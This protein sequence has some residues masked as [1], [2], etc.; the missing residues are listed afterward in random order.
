MAEITPDVIRALA[1][2]RMS[3]NAIISQAVAV[4]DNAGVFA[5]IDEATGYDIDLTDANALPD[6]PIGMWP[7]YTTPLDAA[8]WGDTTRGDMARHQRYESPEYYDAGI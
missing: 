6:S 4:L 3:D 2:L 1:V 8:E 7:T 5:E